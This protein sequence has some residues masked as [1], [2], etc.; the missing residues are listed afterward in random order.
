MRVLA[1][2]IDRSP[3]TLY[4]YFPN[5]EA[6]IEAVRQEAL[7]K[8]ASS[9]RDIDQRCE[10]DLDKVRETCRA[11][12]EF[13]LREPAMYLL[14]YERSDTARP[15]YR[16]IFNSLHFRYMRDK[17][18]QAS[19]AGLLN[20]PDGF[21]VELLVL[22]LWTCL[23]GVIMLRHGLMAE[24]PIFQQVSDRLIKQMLENLEHPHDDWEVL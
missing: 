23:H 12:L 5:R 3:A 9:Y 14:I 13:G 21:T 2:R 1:A 8:L 22:Q 20:L 15:N 19:Q 17:L 11:L 24:E 10:N 6:I 7:K 4:K 18:R 16:Q